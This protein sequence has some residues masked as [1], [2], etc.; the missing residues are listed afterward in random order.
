M[1]LVEQHIIQ[2]NHP[3]YQEIHQDPIPAYGEANSKEVKFSGRRIST[4][5]YRADN[6]LLIYADVNGSLNILRK[7]VPTAFSLGIGGVVVRPV[8][9]IPGAQRA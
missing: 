4:K 2:R 3:H 5:F 7:V 8:G 9:V 6:G 1:Q